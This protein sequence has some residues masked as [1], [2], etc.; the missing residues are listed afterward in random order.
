MHT[1]DRVKQYDLSKCTDTV[2][3][4]AALL[5]ANIQLNT[6]KK[7]QFNVLNYILCYKLYFLYR[8]RLMWYRISETVRDRLVVTMER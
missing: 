1:L 2:S 7:L 8:L 3:E 4:L 5:L 6:R